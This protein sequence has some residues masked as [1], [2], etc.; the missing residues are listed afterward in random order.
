MFLTTSRTVSNAVMLLE[1]RNF[2]LKTLIPVKL[3]WLRCYFL[4]S[5]SFNTKANSV[6]ESQNSSLK[7]GTVKVS[8][9][10]GI[11][12]ATQRMTD[13]ANLVHSRKAISVAT[14][15]LST[16]LW[17]NSGTKGWL[18]DYAEGIVCS[19]MDRRLAYRVVQG[20]VCDMLSNCLCY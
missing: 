9:N 12:T 19:N 15:V 8:S 16:P 6:V 10:L 5:R 2:V 17:S 11:E 7:H 3:Q 14:T 13:Y 20:K 1:I 4:Y 18:T